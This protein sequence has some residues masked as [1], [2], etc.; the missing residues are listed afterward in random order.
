[1]VSKFLLKTTEEYWLSDITTVESFHKELQQDAVNQD[2]QLTGFAYTE[3]PIKEGKEVVDSYFIVKVTKVF[4]D[5]KEPAGVPMET[6]MY[7]RRVATL[8]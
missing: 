4:D 6:V 1:M 5:A 2:Y 3:K 8:D 7:E